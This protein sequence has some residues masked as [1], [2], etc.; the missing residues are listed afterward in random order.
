MNR[1]CAICITCV[2]IVVAAPGASA[3]PASEQPTAIERLIRQEDARWNDPRLGITFSTT[4]QPS[5]VERLVRQEDARSNDPR[6]GLTPTIQAAKA[7]G[8]DW[9][10]AAIGA[11]AGA[12]LLLV[13]SGTV[14]LARGMRAEHSRSAES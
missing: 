7:P 5:A 4:P 10:S 14:V 3:Q 13:L 8:F 11:L 6:L 12:A 1:L 9:L 2:A